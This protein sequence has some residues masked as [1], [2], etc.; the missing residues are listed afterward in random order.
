MAKGDIHT[1]PDPGGKGWKVVREG[2]DRAV[3]RAATQAEADKRG[4]E[5]ARRSKV[6]YSL[7]GRNGQV[8]AKDSYGSDPRRSK[9]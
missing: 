3:A 9:G 1:V 5:T 7:H 8:R 6:E 4:R 2:Q